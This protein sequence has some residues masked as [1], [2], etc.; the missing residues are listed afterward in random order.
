MLDLC[1]IVT[2]FKRYLN[3]Y[4]KNATV[5]E[6]QTYSDIGCGTSR[7][8][9]SQVY[10]FY[11]VILCTLI[12]AR[13]LVAEKIFTQIDIFEQRSTCAGLWNYTSEND[14]EA[15]FAVPQTAP[16]HEPEQPIWRHGKDKNPTNDPSNKHATFISPLY[17]VFS[18][19]DNFQYS[20]RLCLQIRTIRI[21]SAEDDHAA[22]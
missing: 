22:F 6:H 21:E 16:Y 18:E 13:Y 3:G 17:E 12:L 1:T 2:R 5:T 4:R 8:C 19:E 9:S 11:G 7:S 20:K 14:R 10:S 15:H